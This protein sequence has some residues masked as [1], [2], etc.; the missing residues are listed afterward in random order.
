MLNTPLFNSPVDL[1]S[2]APRDLVSDCARGAHEPLRQ[3]SR[4]CQS[5]IIGFIPALFESL[6]SQ[7]AYYRCLAR[8]VSSGAD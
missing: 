2:P 8:A 3:G 4:T 7:R 6:G 1:S 5:L